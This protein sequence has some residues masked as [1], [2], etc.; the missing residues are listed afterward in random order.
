MAKRIKIL[1]TISNFDTSGSG[2][3]VYDLVKGINRDVFEPEIC[4][5]HNKGSYF[6]EIEKLDVKI[7]L[8]PFKTNYRP[9]VTFPFRVLKIRKFFRDHQFD[10]IYSWHWS[11]D[12]SEPLAAK[13]AGVKYIFCKKAMGWGNKAWIWRSKLSTK[14]VAINEDMISEFYKGTSMMDKVVKISLGVDTN[15]FHPLKKTCPEG[16]QIDDTDFVIVS[17]A[18]LVPVKGIEVLFEAVKQ[19][20]NKNIKVFVVGNY[21]N[22]YGLNL[23]AKYANDTTFS[24]LGK[25]LDVRPF[26]AMADLFVIPT[27]NEGRREGLPIAPIEAMASARIVIGSN[28]AGVKDV[29]KA[30][31]QCIFEPNHVSDLAEKIKDVIKMSPIER[32]QLAQAMRTY[33]EQELSM[34]PF[35]QK[36]EDLYLKLIG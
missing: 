18:N 2:K 25:H 30:F 21:D 32:E 14:I 8:F 36:H 15:H 1:F 4:C 9:L 12:F 31:P 10:I 35:I 13:L 34:E 26:L 17:V 27:K 22:D 5:Q 7:H 28:I 11:S 33:V 3:C 29:L 20:N 23:K 16:V 24:F 19:I 6:K